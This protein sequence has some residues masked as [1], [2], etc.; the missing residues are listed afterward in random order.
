MKKP[1]I[2]IDA[3]HFLMSSYNIPRLK[4]YKQKDNYPNCCTYHKSIRA[5][6]NAW[7][8]KFP[9]CCDSCREMASSYNIKKEN[10][11]YVVSKIEEE[12]S[13]SEFFI[14]YVLYHE[15]PKVSEHWY[16][17]ITDYLDATLLSFGHPNIG[18]S[19]YWNSIEHWLTHGKFKVDKVKIT[20]LLEYLKTKESNDTTIN[21]D[22]N[23]TDLNKLYEISQEWIEAIPNL[24]YF[25][26]IKEKIK[27]KLPLNLATYNKQYNQFNGMVSF[28]VYT[29]SQFI[30]VL[31]DLTEK[32]LSQVDTQEIV[33]TLNKTE[34]EQYQA[35][36]IKDNHKIKQNLLLKIQDQEN[37]PF[38]E[39]LQ[40]WLKNEKEFFNDIKPFLKESF[41]QNK[42]AVYSFNWQ[43]DSKQLE[44]IYTNLIEVSFIDKD[45]LKESFIK[46]FNSDNLENEALSIIWITSNRLIAYFFEKLIIEKLLP[47]NCQYASI[48]E[49]TTCF[50]KK[51]KNYKSRDLRTAK[52]DY[53]DMGNPKG[54][55]KID[56]IF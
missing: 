34:F 38:L 33:K 7:W 46:I 26:K 23:N 50:K 54:H 31:K 16:K 56:Q 49:N 37:K 12:I 29:Y 9:E 30:I 28:Q 48:I 24:P 14:E 2:Q 18:A 27:G 19:R 39:V 51:D 21:Q 1:F 47:I 55:E 40:E 41:K 52:K 11:T 32:I 43:G 25:S 53:L 45:T 13:H 44:H 20:L 10:Y 35:Q 15:D 17:H 8:K 3:K 42:K 22:T 36:I 6:I 4:E 5:T